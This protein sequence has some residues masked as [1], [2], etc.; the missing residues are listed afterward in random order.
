MSPEQVRNPRLVD[1]RSDLWSLGVVAYR[2]LSGAYPFPGT[3]TG[4]VL[5]SI[6]STRPARLADFGAP[7]PA[8]AEAAIMRCLSRDREER[9]NNVAELA[10]ALAPFVSPRWQELPHRIG[11]ILAVAPRDVVAPEPTTLSMAEPAAPGLSIPADAPPRALLPIAARANRPEHRALL[12]VGLA[13]L[14]LVVVAIWSRDALRGIFEPRK[15]TLLPLP[16]PAPTAEDLAPPTTA[17]NVTPAVEAAIESAAAHADLG[18]N[19]S[20]TSGGRLKAPAADDSRPYV[21]RSGKTPPSTS[22]KRPP[23]AT[24]APSATSTPSSI[25]HPNPYG[26]PESP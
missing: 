4:E 19:A 9:F 14:V 11:K 7:L 3:T 15:P 23:S 17:Q 22:S 6:L 5:A 1:A 26:R 25:L 12:A 16:L 13:V 20:A 10:F 24:V 2:L 18:P 21:R 8:R